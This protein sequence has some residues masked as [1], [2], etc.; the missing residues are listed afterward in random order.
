MTPNTYILNLNADH[1]DSLY[2]PSHQRFGAFFIFFEPGTT[3]CD[4]RQAL[5]GQG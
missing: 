1:S 5:G 3:H 2:R 4:G